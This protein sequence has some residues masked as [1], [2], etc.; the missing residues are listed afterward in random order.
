MS[1]DWITVAAQIANFLVL[2]WLLK[3]FLYRP[4]LDGID[5]RE[6]EITA[7]MQE[8]VVAKERARKAEQDHLEQV[9]ALHVQQADMAAAVRREAEAQRDALLAEARASLEA[10]RTAAQARQKAEARQFGAKL[11]NAGG[12]ALLSLTRKALTDLADETLEGRIAQHLGTRLGPMA[13]DLRAAAGDGTA[14]IVTS[15][16]ALPSSAQQDLTAHLNHVFPDIP[17]DFQTDPEQAP[18]VIL[19]IG[20][21]Q[22]DW[23]VDGYIDSLD[24]MMG[25]QLDEAS[26]ARKAPDD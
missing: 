22:L 7:R 11:Q 8:A 2:V 23:T 6:A 25:A 18:G 17:V 24:E 3:R 20:G 21:A 9:R 12:A 4:I 16:D 10:E 19:R 14:A 15:H 26:D 13:D 5:A 1:I